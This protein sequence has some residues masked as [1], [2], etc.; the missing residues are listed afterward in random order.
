MRRL[1]TRIYLHFF[2]VLL[3]VGALSSLVFAAGWSASRWR[4]FGHRWV[5]HV[6]NHIGIA[7]PEQREAHM[8]QLS[9]E[10]SYDFVLRAPDGPP[11]IVAGMPLPELSPSE[12]ERARHDAIGLGRLRGRL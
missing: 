4:P 8:R 1:Y 2:G 9:S 7:E 11:L 6:A 5:R 10:L 3:V 12:L